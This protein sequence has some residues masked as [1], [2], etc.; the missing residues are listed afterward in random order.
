M[1]LFLR[2]CGQLPLPVYAPRPEPPCRQA[3]ACQ[4]TGGAGARV[5]DPMRDRLDTDGHAL[6]AAELQWWAAA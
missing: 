6:S 3:V 1:L 4:G 5:G 2:G